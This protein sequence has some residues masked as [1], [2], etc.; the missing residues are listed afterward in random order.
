M[1]LIISIYMIYDIYIPW[2]SKTK[3]RMVFRMI[4]VKDSLLPRGKVWSAWTSWVYIDDMCKTMIL[5]LISLKL[6]WASEVTQVGLISFT[7][8]SGEHFTLQSTNQFD[9]A[10]DPE[11]INMEP[12]NGGGW[13]M[14]V[15]FNWVIFRFNV[16]FPGS[17]SKT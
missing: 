2:E 13:K 7:V 6:R 3:Q 1:I 8:R 10:I 16:D 15:L 5:T 4:H 14:I 12:K 11:K 17:N 9:D